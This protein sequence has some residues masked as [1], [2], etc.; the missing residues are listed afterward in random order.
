M[1]LSVYTDDSA[2]CPNDD[3]MQIICGFAG[4]EDIE[5]L[6][7]QNAL[8]A[9]AG[10]N[11][12][13]E[14]GVIQLYDFDDKSITTIYE[15]AD[16]GELTAGWGSAQCPGPPAGFAPHGIHLSEN[17]EGEIVLLVV[18]HTSREAIEWFQIVET[19]SEKI[20]AEWKGCVILDAELWVND[21]AIIPGAD[22]ALVASHMMAR[23]TAHTMFERVPNDKIRTG[24]VVKWTPE[25][26]WEKVPGT[27]GALP[28]GIQVSDD[29]LTVFNNQYLENK[30]VAVDI[31]TG[32]L[33]WS[34]DI[35]GAPD[36]M[37]VTPDGKLLVASHLF[38]LK[39]IRDECLLIPGDHCPLEFALHYID[40]AN[41]NTELIFRSNKQPFG[42]ATVAVEVGQHIYMGSADGTR[43]GKID[44]PH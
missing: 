31:K 13:N 22:G 38:S 40:S 25:L 8:I 42:G 18:N 3:V 15:L 39:Q 24:Y 27:E 19:D 30:T 29:G 21:V 43:V 2:I 16:G 41:G 17:Q 1:S 20:A 32:K 36:N 9:G 14:N 23:S 5:Y 10:F 33:L 26:G 44:K 11:L 6:P 28:N 4:P 35:L 12:N 7:S 34:T 37:S